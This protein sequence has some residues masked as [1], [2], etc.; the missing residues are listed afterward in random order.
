MIDNRS[1]L[2]GIKPSFLWRSYLYFVFLITLL[3]IIKT[4]E[5]RV[6]EQSIGILIDYEL[7]KIHDHKSHSFYA[8]SSLEEFSKMLDIEQARG[9]DKAN[10]CMDIVSKLK[11]LV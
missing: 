6:R 1:K 4:I 8:V 3:N 11:L 2:R 5:Q 7:V 10:N 9:W